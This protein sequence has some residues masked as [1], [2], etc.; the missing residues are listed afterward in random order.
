M[1]TIPRLYKFLRGNFH[2]I[3]FSET[4]KRNFSMVVVTKLLKLFF[5]LPII[6]KLVLNG[7][8]ENYKVIWILELMQDSQKE[9]FLERFWSTLKNG[10][11]Y[12]SDGGSFSLRM[13]LELVKSV[14]SQF[15]YNKIFIDSNIESFGSSCWTSQNWS[16]FSNSID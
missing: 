5:W 10:P 14:F 13:L 11:K 3:Q 6:M 16:S 8:N 7:L 1:Q 15:K 4:S 9:P 2:K 12:L